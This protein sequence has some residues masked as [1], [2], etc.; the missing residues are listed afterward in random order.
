MRRLLPALLLLAA[1]GGAERQETL[2]R[3]PSFR[4]RT[5]AVAA[6]RG[7]RG[8]G[9]EIS[10]A[11]VRRLESLGLTASALE[12]SDSVLAG[13]AI[14][15]EAAR[16]PRLLDE[17]RRATGADAVAFLSLDPAWRGLEVSALDARTGDA[18]LR[19]VAHPRGE[20]FADAA[21]IADAASRALAP[22]A[23]ERRPARAARPDD[24]VDEIPLP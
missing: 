22:L 7:A 13:S 19:A 24:P 18:V 4:A 3:A 9:V 6:T 2:S 1:C 10:R 14:G 5:V 17:I 23:S 20:A 8:K 15:L 16:N 21:E 12:E 11:L